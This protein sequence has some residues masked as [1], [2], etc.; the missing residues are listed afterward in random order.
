[1]IGERVG[2]DGVRRMIGERIGIEDEMI[3]GRVDTDDK[4]I[5]S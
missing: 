4:N 2:I 3:D 5:F 1:M